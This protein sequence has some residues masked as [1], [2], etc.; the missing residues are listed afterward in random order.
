MKSASVTPG[1]KKN[2]C[3]WN[4]AMCRSLAANSTP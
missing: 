4:H 1:R 3:A 2:G